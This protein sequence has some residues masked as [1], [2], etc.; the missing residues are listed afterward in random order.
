MHAREVQD[1]V[2]EVAGVAASIRPATPIGLG[3]ELL[4]DCAVVRQAVLRARALEDL[5]AAFAQLPE[6]ERGTLL[7]AGAAK[8][9]T[10]AATLDRQAQAIDAAQLRQAFIPNVELPTYLAAA[11]IIVIPYHTLLT[12]GIL[13]W[14][15]SYARPVA[16]PAFGP[17]RELEEVIV[18]CPSCGEPCALSVDTS[19]GPEQSYFEDCPTCCAP[20]EVFV[21]SRPGEIL[22]IS[23]T[24]D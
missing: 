14:A 4:H 19:A 18:D 17:V 5:L 21:K 22:S 23:V 13:L 16:A 15:F 1:Q 9:S 3:D 24:A 12:S 6:Q 10:Y 8:D 7:I 2:N 11:D 20:M